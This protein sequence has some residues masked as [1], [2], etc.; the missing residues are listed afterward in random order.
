VCVCVCVSHSAEHKAVLSDFTH[1]KLPL[2]MAAVHNQVQQ[3][4]M[5][6]QEELMAQISAKGAH[7]ACCVESSVVCMC[8]ACVSVCVCM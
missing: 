6:R 7:T 2:A 1:N 8:L 4:H 5:K 3:A